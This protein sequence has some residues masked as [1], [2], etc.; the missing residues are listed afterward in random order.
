METRDRNG[1]ETSDKNKMRWNL[2]TMKPKHVSAFFFLPFSLRY[3]PNLEL[4]V[5]LQVNES[6]PWAAGA[7]LEETDGLL[8]ILRL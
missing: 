1:R 4:S 5:L 3:E 7:F 6:V 2:S 8:L